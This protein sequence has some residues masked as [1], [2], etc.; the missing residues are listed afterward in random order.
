MTSTSDNSIYQSKKSRIDMSHLC[1][2]GTL[3]N[4]AF[5]FILLI[6]MG[7]ATFRPRLTVRFGFWEVYARP[8]CVVNNFISLKI[9][10]APTRGTSPNPPNTLT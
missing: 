6:L 10:P 4:P 3:G 7:S 8:L 5:P 1:N 9:F 2:R